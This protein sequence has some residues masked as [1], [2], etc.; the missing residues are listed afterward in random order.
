MQ[1][2]VLPLVIIGII[3]VLFVALHLLITRTR[4]G[5]LARATADD[6]ETIQYFGVDYARSIGS[7]W[8]SRRRRVC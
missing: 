6:Y 5:R 4:F 8:A 3:L 7:P 1:I 2:G